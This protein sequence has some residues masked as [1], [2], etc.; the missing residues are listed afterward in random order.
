MCFPHL[1]PVKNRPLA[2]LLMFIIAGCSIQNISAVLDAVAE[3][4]KT[5]CFE[6]SCFFKIYNYFLRLLLQKY[7]SQV[8]LSFIQPLFKDISCFSAESLGKK[9]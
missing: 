4:R 6:V 9:K 2:F 1:E 5:N 7:R 3:D 8:F